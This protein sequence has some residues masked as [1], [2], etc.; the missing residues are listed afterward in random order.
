MPFAWLFIVVPE[1]SLVVASP[2]TR[3]LLDLEEPP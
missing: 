2:L 3:Y 1:Q